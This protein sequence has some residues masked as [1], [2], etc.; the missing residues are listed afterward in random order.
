MLFA[1]IRYLVACS[2]CTT[3]LCSTAM[4]GPPADC[5]KKHAGRW[6][7]T[8]RATGQTYPADLFPNGTGVSHCPGCAPGTWTCS[9]NTSTVFVNGQTVVSTLSPDGLSATSSC[10][11]STRIGRAPAVVRTPTVTVTEPKVRAPTAIVTEPK[12]QA[13]TVTVTEPA[14]RA[15]TVRP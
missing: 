1:A 14:V 8:V 7:I 5:V 15:P 6:Q 4:A 2:V 10:C 3:W 12:V 9:G 13:P 11:T